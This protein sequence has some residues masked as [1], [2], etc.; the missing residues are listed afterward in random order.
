MKPF[1]SKFRRPTA[2]LLPMAVLWAAPVAAGPADQPAKTNLHH[3]VFILPANPEEGRDPF[4][5]KSNRPYEAATAANTN[6]NS[7]EVTA[8][9]YKGTSGTPDHRLVII[10]NH[11]FAAG[12]EEDVLTAQGRIHVRCVE[13]RPHSVVIETGGQYHELT[14]SDNP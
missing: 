5:P 11:T 7:T 1:K 8:L 9:V 12:D 14:S 10:N 13:I 6:T 2:V 3:S 4:F